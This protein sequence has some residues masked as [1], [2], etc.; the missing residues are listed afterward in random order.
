MSQ[1]MTQKSIKVL[2]VE[3][4]SKPPEKNHIAKKIDFYYIDDIWSLDTLGF[5]DYEPKNNRNFR[6]VLVVIDNLGKFGWIFPLKSK[7]YNKKRLVQKHFDK[8]KRKT[9]CI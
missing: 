4:H 3:I 2:V 5:K 7:C 8:I 6:Y 1:Q 9:K